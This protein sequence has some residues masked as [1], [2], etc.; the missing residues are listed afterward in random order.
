MSPRPS[1]APDIT[2]L[3]LASG[4]SSSAPTNGT[5]EVHLL[6]SRQRSCVTL[7]PTFKI[8]GFASRD[9]NDV[10]RLPLKCPIFNHGQSLQVYMIEQTHLKDIYLLLVCK[11]SDGSWL[12]ATTT[13]HSDFV[14][15]IKETLIYMQYRLS[16]P[17]HQQYYCKHH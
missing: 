5:E 12:W 4:A 11:L 16:H 2:F 9:R 7:Q 14:L 13:D 17:H 8:F 6:S 10:G 15:A 3:A 1:Q